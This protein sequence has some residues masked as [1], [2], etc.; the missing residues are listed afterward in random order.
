MA[1]NIPCFVIAAA[2][3]LASC[4]STRPP[5]RDPLPFHVALV[6]TVG[7][8]VESTSEDEDGLV[9]VTIDTRRLDE[10]L[11]TELES[12]GF[13]RVTP[14]ALPA[15][16]APA[17]AAAGLPA[18][19]AKWDEIAR[20]KWWILAARQAD[21]DMIARARVAYRPQA[22][23]E[24]N[25]RFWLNLP[26]FLIGG[27]MCWF[28]SDRSYAVTAGLDL[29]LYD[30]GLVVEE[31]APLGPS[32]EL[33]SYQVEYGGRAL[34]FLDRADGVSSYL[35]SVVVPAG[36]LARSNET[37]SGALAQDAEVKLCEALTNRVQQDR[38]NLLRPLTL[39]F[40]IPPGELAA[41]RLADGKVEV[42]G[43][44]H[45]RPERGVE[46]L[47]YYSIN[48]GSPIPFDAPKPLADGSF[49]ATEV[50]AIK[51]LASLPQGEGHA[52]V[53]VVQGGASDRYRT[54]TVP[55]RAAP[56]PN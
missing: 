54:F 19:P 55:V 46:S 12:A 37:V 24:L 1:R 56:L 8:T 5:A 48:D 20:A 39:N 30:L 2:T 11:R 21:A 10:R 16:G 50:Y 4:A 14:L 28:V 53:R 13:A 27:P 35:L 9:P 7:Q 44:V 26:L 25:D 33:G 18:D 36:L 29:R 52:R 32:T 42:A 31:L 41:T 23:G 47:L 17:I 3:S 45:F 22:A 38:A 6:P 40:S 43:A 49:D 15:I 34:G 51:S